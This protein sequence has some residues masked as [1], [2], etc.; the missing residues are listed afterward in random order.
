MRTCPRASEQTPSPF[1]AS[2]NERAHSFERT[3]LRCDNPYARR[4]LDG[5]EREFRILVDHRE[6][7]VAEQVRVV[8]RFRWHLRGLSQRLLSHLHRLTEE[9]DERKERSRRI[10]VIALT[11]GEGPGRDRRRYVVPL[12]GR[13]IPGS[14]RRSP[15]PRRPAS[16][17]S[18]LDRGARDIPAA[19]LTC[20]GAPAICGFGG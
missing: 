17:S 10:P 2:G 11:A 6:D 7:I 14:D 5:T 16:S 3:A 19:A 8:S 20:G 12:E 4:R 1:K 18:P 9:I 15:D 13:C